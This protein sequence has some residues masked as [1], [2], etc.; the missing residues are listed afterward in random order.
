M[1]VPVIFRALQIL[2]KA[3]AWRKITLKGENG[4]FTIFHKLNH[5]NKGVRIFLEIKGEVILIISEENA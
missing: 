2:Q 5:E 4:T 1:E 3:E